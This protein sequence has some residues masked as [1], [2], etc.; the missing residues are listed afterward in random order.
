MFRTLVSIALRNLLAHKVKTGV[1]GIILLSGTVLVLLGASLLTTI[2]HSMSES[3]IGSIAGHL[4]ISS[5]K[6]KDKLVLFPGPVDGTDFGHLEDF[7]TLRKEIEA[8][9][10]VEAVIPMG[11]SMALVFGGNLVDVKLQELREAHGKEDKE[12]YVAVRDHVKRIVKLLSHDMKNLEAILDPKTVEKGIVEGIKD[13]RTAAVDAWGADFDEKWA[14]KIVFL[15]NKVARM[16]IGEDLIPMRFMGTDP[17][18]FSK[19]FS[20]FEIARG[21]MIPKGKRGFLFAEWAYEEFIKHKTARR[22]DKMK[23]ALADGDRL[24][25]DE[26]LQEMRKQNGKQYKEVTYQ[27][28]DASAAEVAT[29][30][31]KLLGS[32]EQD[33]VKLVQA[34]FD[35]DDDN[36]GQRY[37]FFY[38]VIA[39]HLQL[40]KIGIGDHVTLRGVA[41][42][43][44]PTSVHVKAYGTFRFK[45][46]EKSALAGAV[47][48]M[49]IHSFRDLYG[50]LTADKKEELEKIKEDSGVEDVNR[51]SAEDDLF[52]GG[53]DEGDEGGGEAVDPASEGTAAGFDEFAGV[54]MD[55]G[56]A[57]Y[58]KRL[59]ERVYTEADIEGGIVNNAAVVLKSRGDIRSVKAQLTERSEKDKLEITVQ[60]W[61]EASGTLGYLVFVIWTVLVVAILGVFGVALFIV[62]NSMV[63]ATMERTRE[64]GTMRAI[65]AQRRMILGMFLTES[66]T[67]GTVFGAIGV[68]V[69]LG[70]IGVANA[71]GIPAVNDFLVFLFGGPR[72]HPETSVTHV[73]VA[74]ILVVLVTVVSSLYPAWL[75][76]RVPPV[77]AMSEE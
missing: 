68:V 59:E 69:G 21:Q 48:V 63:M 18:R 12:R 58:A 30:L 52:G 47:H 49:D 60:T 28:D 17:E 16:A 77:E 31:R 38:D 54:D 11:F 13:V 53:D 41:K 29:A 70:I 36:F 15:E 66:L 9:P 45:S 32:G 25:T 2:D 26:K 37:K 6:G 57:T 23:D 75:A 43:G 3:L 35:C 4:Q 61:Q 76:T 5:A 10:E 46:L 20:R 39:P 71:Q 67:I 1:V 64:I 73:V 56:A 50:H 14:E 74:M 24:A 22:L 27:L 44:Y 7:P 72:L 55:I 51:D 42:G 19:H 65:G 8:L 40:Y 62:N 34:F 33:L